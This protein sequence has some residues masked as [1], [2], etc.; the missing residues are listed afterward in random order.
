ATRR[1]SRCWR[2]AS[3]R[4]HARNGSALTTMCW[5]TAGPS[6][7]GRLPTPCERRV[8]AC[9]STDGVGIVGA[10]PAVL[11]MKISIRSYVIA[12]AASLGLLCAMASAASALTVHGSVQ[13]V[14]VVAAHAHQRIALLNRRGHVVQSRRAGSLGGVVYRGIKPGPGYRVRPAGGHASH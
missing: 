11:T 8:V 2:V 9:R 3:S 10:G 6:C 4:R 14:Y 1:P 7:T 13:Q 12:L 5:P